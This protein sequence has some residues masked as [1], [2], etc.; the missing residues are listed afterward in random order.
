MPTKDNS[1]VP[2]GVRE[3]LSSR[4]SN[5]LTTPSTLDTDNPNTLYITP[6]TSDTPHTFRSGKAKDLSTKGE[7]QSRMKCSQCGKSYLGQ[8]NSSTCGDKCRQR[9]SRG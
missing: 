3:E 8:K 7:H 1:N 4:V 5:T 9:K 6:I 2:K